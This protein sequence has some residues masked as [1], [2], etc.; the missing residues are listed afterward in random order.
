MK[1]KL[2]KKVQRWQ[3]VGMMSA[4]PTGPGGDGQGN[5]TV[6][7]EML[8]ATLRFLDKATGRD[9]TGNYPATYHRSTPLNKIGIP[10]K[11]RPTLAGAFDQEVRATLVALGHPVAGREIRAD[12][13]RHV[14]TIESLCRM[15]CGVYSVPVPTP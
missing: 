3:A 15:A 9:I 11:S 1:R 10:A 13:M 4:S 8:V 14:D 6:Y 2:K 7:N 5:A 12:D